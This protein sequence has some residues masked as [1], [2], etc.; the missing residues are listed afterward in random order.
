MR[1]LLVLAVVQ[2]LHYFVK[3]LSWFWLEFI[4]G[5]SFIAVRCKKLHSLEKIFNK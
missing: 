3:T 1:F 2:F 4:C 5:N